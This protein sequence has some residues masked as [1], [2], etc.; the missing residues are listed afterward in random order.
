MNPE[1]Y[2]AQGRRARREHRLD[3]SRASFVEA[4]ASARRSA[5]QEILARALQG[6]G[7]AE[8]DL[9]NREAARQNYEEAV[10][11]LRSLN[12]PLPL[13]HAVRHVGDILV[14]EDRLESAAPWYEEALTIYRGD[15]TRHPLDFANAIRG[16]ALLQERR[17][18]PAEALA[19]W[20]EAR[21]LYA[22]VDVQAGVEESERRVAILSK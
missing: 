14:N 1:A 18:N 20:R 17:G 7:Q 11:I 16:Y 4:V 2:I 5:D 6:L 8:R 12:D 9:E 21:E 19:L 13:A 22:A 10:T 15:E 3:A